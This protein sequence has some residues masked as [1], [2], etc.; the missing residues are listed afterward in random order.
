M[1]LFALLINS[2]K[3]FAQDTPI[4]TVGPAPHGK[5]TKP[6]KPDKSGFGPAF[7]GVSYTFL[8]KK[9][10]LPYNSR[11]TVVV[12]YHPIRKSFITGYQGTFIETFGKWNTNL[13]ANY[14]Q[15]EWSYF[16]GLGNNSLFNEPGKVYNKKY[17][18]VSNTL[19]NAGVGTERIFNDYHK[20]SISPFFQSVK[21]K[22]EKDS[23]HYVYKSVYP[24]ETT[25]YN[26][27]NFGGIALDYVFQKINDSVLPVK[28]IVWLTN[29]S[30]VH[31][32]TN[33]N[34]SFARYS[35]E[36]NYYQ[37]I[38]QKLGFTI[39]AGAASLSGTPEFYQYN[40]VGGT[41]TL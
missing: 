9:D 25:V 38:T 20:I 32:I 8:N 17:D 18:R 41:Q 19:I 23:N 28:G 30:Y 40:F 7:L 21:I 6:F 27:S 12:R 15:V 37:P 33:S 3:V 14:Y 11:Q 10:K 22:A 26:T 24:G 35:T 34:R 31:N 1:A 4:D 16:Y 36:I 2:N 5:I 39:R 29:F 13:Y